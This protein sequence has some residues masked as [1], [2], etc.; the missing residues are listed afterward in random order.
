MA[1]GMD[2]ALAMDD[3][4]TVP[5]A[6]AHLR[7]ALG[8]ATAQQGDG[9]LLARRVAEQS[10]PELLH[11][12]L[13]EPP[14]PPEH[15]RRVLRL[16]LRELVD[17]GAA[18]DLL[19]A[20]YHAD[21]ASQREA[22]LRLAT[23]ADDA[24]LSVIAIEAEDH[25]TRLSAAESIADVTS[26]DT[27]LKSA[28]QRDRRVA[29]AVR[30][31]L[32]HRADE[33][34]RQ[35]ERRQRREQSCAA[36]EELAKA[37]WH[38]SYGHQL[39]HRL[40]KWRGYADGAPSELHRRVAGAQ[41]RCEERVEAHRRAVQL[42][43]QM[44]CC[45][46]LLEEALTPLRARSVRPGLAAAELPPLDTAALRQVLQAQEGLWGAAL[47]E[48]VSPDDAL[49]ERWQRLL[50]QVDS[51]CAAVDLVITKQSQLEQLLAETEQDESLQA[52]S[53]RS[54]RLEEML[55]HLEWPP[56]FVEPALL[57]EL[58]EAIKAQ[59]KCCRRLER[60]ERAVEE[61]LGVAV[62][63]LHG[64][65]R[66]GHSR[67]ASALLRRI[68]AEQLPQLGEVA[69]QRGMQA[70]ESA[71]KRLDELGEW[72]DFAARPKYIALCE[73]MERLARED[74]H[75]RAKAAR[76]K[77][78]QQRWQ[79]LGRVGDE[80][81][82]QRFRGLSERAFE[83]CAAFFTREQAQREQNL[84]QR[85]K[86]CTQLADGLEQIDPERPDWR[87][88]MVLLQR[89]DSQWRKSGPVPKE[90]REEVEQRYRQLRTELDRHLAPARA[91]LHRQR[92]QLIDQARALAVPKDA[93]KAKL[94]QRH[95]KTLMA[96]DDPQQARD[97]QAVM[98]AFF[99][100]A[101]S[102]HL[103]RQRERAEQQA[104]LR[105]LSAALRALEPSAEEEYYRQ[106]CQEADALLAEETVT[107]DE[108]A[109]LRRERERCAERRQQHMTQWRARTEREELGRRAELCLRL[110]TADRA[111]RAVLGEELAPQ[112]S[113]GIDLPPKPHKAMQRRWAAAMAGEPVASPQERRLACIRA[114]LL[115]DIDSPPEDSDLRTA[116]QLQNM[117]SQGLKSQQTSRSQ[118]DALRRE[119][120]CG[121]VAD[122][123]TEQ[124][125]SGRFVAAV[126]ALEQQLSAVAERQRKT[127]AAVAKRADAPAR[128]KKP[129]RRHPRS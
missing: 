82:W 3:Q 55:E 125:L 41:Q 117:Q 27:V 47:A 34:R 91:A 28:I 68:E 70:L 77:A 92:Q 33:Q 115:A 56:A 32:A 12:L 72:R 40:R 94:M 19:S 109:K 128:K 37:P 24:A 88:T 103:H 86:L 65:L 38:S 98:D 44:K 46:E 9:L 81:L 4:V 35:Q 52:A 87:Q 63:R 120:L 96:G 16:R 8:L 106:L 66:R 64:L 21:P 108:A 29:R 67:P 114:E 85:E 75:P 119:W 7:A 48:G 129:R 112:W 25:G 99:A 124:S 105:D 111:A 84:Q 127:L 102:E 126:E 76:I 90:K 30:A 59:R 1:S 17:D 110:E 79:S 51:F 54:E 97:F 118:V 20:L 13:R 104:K 58:R 100:S 116:Y 89:V 39:A 50:T 11:A 6:I 18:G 31:R 22:V 53:E 10:Q 62:K 23:V 2:R 122:P 95:F 101:E 43:L 121:P 113:S 61:Q 36:L 93:Q 42:P 78:L 57:A 71:K 83:P 74:M 107:G 14:V 69:R 123:V 5:A 80:D 60:D 49:G 45:C 26:L 73:E 15:I